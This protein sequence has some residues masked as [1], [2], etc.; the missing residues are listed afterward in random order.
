MRTARVVAAAT[1]FLAA[2]A[3]PA[4]A[5][6]PRTPVIIAADAGAPVSVSAGDEFF[7]ALDSNPTTGYAWT[8]SI[9]DGKVLAYEGNVYQPPSSGAIGAGGQQIFIY[10][11]NRSGATTL[12]FAYARSFES[13]VPPVKTLTFHITVQ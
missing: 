5:L 2:L 11:A 13:G 3:L 7:V 8:Q 6:Q 12:V 1:L 10:H 9:G 4:S